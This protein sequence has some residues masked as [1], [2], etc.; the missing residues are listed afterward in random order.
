MIYG[1]TGTSHGM[2]AAQTLTV[3]GLLYKAT[4][5]HHGDCVGADAEVHAIC[6][7][8][9]IPLHGHPTV[10]ERKRAFC[11]NFTWIEQPAEYL[12]RNR[13]IVEHGVD[14]LLAAP[15]T[16]YEVQRS[17]VW[18][19]I[20]FARLRNERLYVPRPIVI[21]HPDGSVRGVFR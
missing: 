15:R 19:T 1:F 16:D 14:G 9:G 5:V 7:D 12:I 4:I 8:R 18:H 20:R 10:N 6:L 2:T 17:G 21:V 11:Q 13:A 3:A